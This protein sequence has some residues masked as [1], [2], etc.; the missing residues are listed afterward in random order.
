[1]MFGKNAVCLGQGWQ[2]FCIHRIVLFCPARVDNRFCFQARSQGAQIP[3]QH[4]GAWLPCPAQE[5]QEIYISGSHYAAS[6]VATETFPACSQKKQFGIASWIMNKPAMTYRVT[7]S[8]WPWDSR[9][10][11]WNSKTLAKKCLRWVLIHIVLL[12]SSGLQKTRILNSVCC[13]GLQFM[14]DKDLIWNILWHVWWDSNALKYVI[15]SGSNSFYI[16]TWVALLFPC[17]GS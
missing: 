16:R 10:G 6:V 15:D 12:C 11:K 17:S 3:A 13:I 5:C 8:S 14:L 4:W 9:E 2:W 7:K 1:M